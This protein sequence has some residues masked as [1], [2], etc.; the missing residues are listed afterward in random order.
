MQRKTQAARWSRKVAPWAQVP[1]A[2]RLKAA[3]DDI[4]QMCL[5]Y[6]KA[7]EVYAR[8]CISFTQ[9]SHT[10]S[11]LPFTVALI[12]VVSRL[13]LLLFELDDAIREAWRAVHRLYSGINPRH[14]HCRCKL[15]PPLPLDSKDNIPQSG[16]AIRFDQLPPGEDL[17]DTIQRPQPL[18]GEIITTPFLVVPR[19][20]DISQ[21]AGT[22]PT[23]DMEDMMVLDLDAPVIRVIPA[24]PLA[25][26]KEGT[27]TT[28]MPTTPKPKKKKPKV[29]RDVI[30]EIF[31]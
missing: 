14:K 17:G 13:R 27:P 1:P 22:P 26:R 19:E 6:S 23:V 15:P 3:L 28:P 24:A 30:D 11:F 12:A 4:R 31:G 16:E 7:I 25:A 29:K 21:A 9:L 18:S 5:L 10:T 8:A 2:K 20:E